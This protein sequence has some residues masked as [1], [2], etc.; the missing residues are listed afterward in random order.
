MSDVSQIDGSAVRLRREA[1]GWALNDLATRACLSVKQ[2]KQIEEGG[3]SSFYSESV[4]LTAARKVA[5]LLQLSEAQLFGQV[6]APPPQAEEE[7]FLFAA[8]QATSVSQTPVAPVGAASY[9]PEPELSGVHL[10]RSEPLHFLAQPPE[11]ESGDLATATQALQPPT[12]ASD[13]TDDRLPPV[14][15]PAQEAADAPSE[16]NYF[17]KILVL[18]LVAIAV[19]A[20]LRP[21]SAENSAPGSEN[22]TGQNM[23][24]PSVANPSESGNSTAIPVT[25]P[26][27]EVDP[28]AK[29][30]SAADQAVTPAATPS[31]AP[32]ATTEQR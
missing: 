19:A 15:S 14:A 20:L 17:L 21:K 22:N 23:S 11:P 27:A 32:A 5:S 9:H 28:N 18:F 4:K 16:N 7:S 1:Q 25:G 26:S 12:I 13:A 31:T 30:A 8:N 24:A 29:P 3:L 6:T 2:I 10:I